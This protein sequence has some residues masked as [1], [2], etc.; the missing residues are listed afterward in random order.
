M[1]GAKP[2]PPLHLYNF[3][4]WFFVVQRDNSYYVYVFELRIQFDFTEAIYNLV[5]GKEC[6]EQYYSP[7]LLPIQLQG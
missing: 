1:Y 3:A 7:F 2:P 5:R 6:M 4:A